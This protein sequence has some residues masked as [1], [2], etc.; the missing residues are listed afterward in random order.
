MYS[1]LVEAEGFGDRKAPAGL[2][3]SPGG[4]SHV[5]IFY[6]LMSSSN[7]FRS[8]SAGVQKWDFPMAAALRK[9]D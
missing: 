8:G 9:L 2:K 5:E 3:P 4:S 1:H 7:S 6:P